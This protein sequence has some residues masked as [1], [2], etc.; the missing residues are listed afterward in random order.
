MSVYYDKARARW[1]WGFKAVID[2]ERHRFSKLLP[3]GWS[4]TQAKRYDE[5]ETARTYARLSTGKRTSA[6]PLIDTVVGLYLTERVPELRDGTNSARNLAHLLPHF[7]GKG[8][9]EMADVARKYAKAQRGKLKP[10]TIR[11]R[12]ATLRS[13]ASHALKQHSIG[14]A[15][16]I[17]AMPMPSVSNERHYY[18]TRAEL[19]GL[20]RAVKDPA[21]RAW[22]ILT[23]ATGS[24]PG[25]LFHAEPHDGYFLMPM[26][27]NGERE[28][29]PVL[30]QLRRYMRYWPMPHGYTWHSKKFREARK[31]VG[32]DHIHPHD[33]RH[34]TASVLASN[35]ASLLQVGR[36]LGHRTAQASN[37]YAHLYTQEKAALLGTV[38]Q[39]RP[40]KKPRAA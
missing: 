32:L 35:G 34:S 26:P 39:K 33:L 2:G 38:W 25:E 4:E 37:R 1:R 15:D 16:W 14:S 6:I 7:Q 29:K 18:L 27:K 9:D 11:Q 12:L 21:T 40:H 24:R 36:V 5:Q 8:L 3:V 31:A 30:T 10:A 23:F 22:V 19:L 20:A 17:A 28:I 13:A